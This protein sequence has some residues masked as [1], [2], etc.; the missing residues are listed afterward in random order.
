MYTCWMQNNL[1][2]CI[3]VLYI[4]IY[5]W[6]ICLIRSIFMLRLC[7]ENASFAFTIHTWIICKV[8]NC[9]F[10]LMY[11]MEKR[12]GLGE[13]KAINFKSNLLRNYNNATKLKVFIWNRFHLNYKVF[14]PDMRWTENFFTP[15]KWTATTTIYFYAKLKFFLK[16]PLKDGG[17][18]H[19]VKMFATPKKQL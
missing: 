4:C 12:R 18:N 2:L 11:R 9:A 16:L 13:S 6:Q 14:H 7:M 8:I 15:F 19:F 17:H 3:Y 10:I 5:T 1:Y